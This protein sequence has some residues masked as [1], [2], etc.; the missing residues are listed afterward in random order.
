V[1]PYLECFGRKVIYV[2]AGDEARLV[3][4]R[5]NLMLGVVTQ[6][7]AEITLLAEA[8]GVSRSDFLEFSTTA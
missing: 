4:I 1:S 5:H 2:G 3:K 7:M 8:A 6:T